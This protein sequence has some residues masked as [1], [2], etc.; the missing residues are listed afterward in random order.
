MT[1]VGLLFAMGLAYMATF[2]QSQQVAGTEN[3]DL[4]W[5]KKI[6]NGGIHLVVYQPQLDSWKRAIDPRE[7]ISVA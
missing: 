2:A 6:D 1:K 7:S 3:T 4:S 5:P